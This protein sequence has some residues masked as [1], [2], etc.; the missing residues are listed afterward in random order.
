MS[1]EAAPAF[2]ILDQRDLMI[3]M[4]DGVRLATNVFLPAQ[5]RAV[6]TGR[7]SAVVERTPYGKDFALRLPLLRSTFVPAGYAVVVQDVRGRY[8]SEGRWRPLADDG[9]DAADLFAWIAGQPWSDGKVGMVGTS[10]CGGTQHAAALAE[11]PHLAAVVP[12][13]AMCNPGRFGIRY[14]GAFEL[15][16][17]NWAVTVGNPN[18]AAPE[19]SVDPANDKRSHAAAVER[20]SS[21]AAGRKALAALPGRVR[22]VALGLPSS[23]NDLAPAPDYRAWLVQALAH[24]GNDAFWTEMGI[25]VLDHLD[26]WKDVPAI[27]VTGAYDSWAGSVCL[28]FAA[29]AKAKKSP[30]RLLFGPWTHGRQFES[31]SGQAEFGPDAAIDMRAV[32]RRWFDRWMKGIDNGAERDPAVRVFVMGGGDGRR[33]PEDRFFV[34]G[35]WRDFDAWPPAEGR[36]SAFH[37]HPAGRL[38]SAPAAAS[39]PSDFAFD[40]DDPI[41][42]VGGN[43]SSQGPLMRAGAYEQGRLDARRDVLRFITEPLEEALDVIGPVAI[44]LWVSSESSEMDFT[45]KLVDVWPSGL[46]LNIADGIARI[47]ELHRGEPRE[48]TIEPY[49]TAVRFERG[50]RIRL[51][52]SSSNFPRFDINPAA[53]RATNRVFHDPEHPSRLLLQV[54]QA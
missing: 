6:A 53:P 2:D 36:E 3:A 51:D 44:R 22:D 1:V 30:Q 23:A 29:L 54:V 20:A 27:H 5:A 10:Y 37:L 15:R 18:I 28:T 49:P 52:V 26:A 13:D 21:D 48:V 9:A 19:L 43:V 41:P 25:S 14:A 11:A 8:G 35:R 46:A 45:A 40:P 16:W 50:H 12:V 32:E 38:A 42:A 4:R 17:L 31:F 34:G 39:A 33:T 24:G 7:F 47:A